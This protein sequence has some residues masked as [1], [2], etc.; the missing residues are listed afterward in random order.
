MHL[1]EISFKIY[2]TKFR[3]ILLKTPDWNWSQI[4]VLVSLK[5]LQTLSSTHYFLN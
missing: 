2:G 4:D 3:I 1:N 5:Y